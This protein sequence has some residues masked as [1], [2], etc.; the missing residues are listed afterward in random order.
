MSL[1]TLHCKPSPVPDVWK[2]FVIIL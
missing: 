1:R 2:N